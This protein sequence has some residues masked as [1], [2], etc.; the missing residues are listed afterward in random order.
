M[1]TVAEIQSFIRGNTDFSPEGFSPINHGEWSQTYSFSSGGRG[2]IFRWSETDEDFSKDSFAADNYSKLSLPIPKI[3]LLQKGLGGYIAISEMAEGNPID[4][5]SQE[6]MSKLMPAVLELLDSFRNT[7]ISSTTGFGSWNGSGS[8]PYQSLSE[9]L[10]AVAEE[11]QTSRIKGAHNNLKYQGQ[12]Y[13]HFLDGIK[14]LESL[15][16]YCPN[17]RYLVHA[18]L[19]HFNLLVKGSK[20]SAVLDWGCSM[21][22]DYLYE[23]AWFTYFL[24]WHKYMQHLDLKETFRGH[25]ISQNADVT[26]FEE[27]LLAYEIH[28]GL[29]GLLYC[30]FKNDWITAREVAIRTQELITSFEI[31]GKRLS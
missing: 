24:P 12:L 26:N 17:R 20:I 23:V 3:L 29:D 18:D 14:A 16:T 22:G 21:Y 31:S 27:R 28:I 4:L 1:K 9:H 11:G 7:D 8:A 13:Q 30:A 25:L 5:V 10:L 19:L 6:Q 15:L 2:L